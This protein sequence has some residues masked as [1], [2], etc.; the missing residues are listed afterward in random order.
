MAKKAT[1]K[2]KANTSA[3][4]ELELESIKAENLHLKEEVERLRLRN[5]GAHPAAA[6]A[7]ALRSS[8]HAGDTADDAMTMYTSSKVI[9]SELLDLLGLFKTTLASFEERLDRLGAAGPDSEDAFLSV[10]LRDGV[11]TALSALDGGRRDAKDRSDQDEAAEPA[12]KGA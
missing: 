5:A 12:A 9:Q 3:L 1:R 11:E 8:D 7:D 10:D 2:I 4:G 6:L